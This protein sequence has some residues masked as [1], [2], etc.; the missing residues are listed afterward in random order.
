MTKLSIIAEEFLINGFSVLPAKKD[1]S[2]A[3]VSWKGLISRPMTLEY[4]EEAFQNAHFIGLIC[5]SVS[6]GIECID[7]DAHGKDIETIYKQFS[8]EHGVSAILNNNNIYI[9][10]SP[11]GGIHVIYRY[12]TTGERQ[13][14]LKLAYWEDDTSMIET[15]GTGG[16]VIVAPSE[17]Y[18][19]VRGDLFKLSEISLEER[20][21][22]MEVARR[23]NR[24]TKKE[25]QDKS[26]ESGHEYIDP[27]DWFNY[28][29]ADAAK[30][31]LKDEG[32][33]LIRIDKQDQVEHWRRPGKAKGTSATWGYKMN[34]FYPFTSSDGN[35]QEKKYYTPFQI[36]TILR[37]K[38][39]F[40]AA[41]SYVLNKYL[42]DKCDYIRVGVDY[43][44]KIVKRDRYMIE[45]IEL[46]PWKKDEIKQDHGAKYLLSIPLY[47][48]FTI[49]PDNRNYQ[50]IYDNCFNLYK[51]FRHQP[52]PGSYKW[53]EILLKHVFG[54]QYEIGLRYI[55]ALYLH[56][57]R[58]LP[59]LVLVSK[60]RQ[61]GKTTFINWLN[62]V[63]GNNMTNIN[64]EDLVSQF[65][66]SYATSN[67]IAVEETLIEKSVTVEK[68]KALA[69]GKFI[70]VNNKF[71]NQYKIPFFGKI[72][73]ASNNEDKFAKIDDE[74]IRFFVRK[75][76]IPKIA[77]HNI[78]EDMVAEIPAFLH[79][80]T[81]LPDID[82]SRDRSG[83]TPDEI[84]NESLKN[85]K[86][87]S[88]SGL[89]KDL[90]ELFKDR[91]MHMNATSLNPEISN[92]K[93][94]Y[95]TEIFAAPIDIK[96]RWFDKNSRIDIQYIKSVLKNEFMKLPER[97]MRYV[98]FNDS[99]SK[100]GTPYRFDAKEF[101]IDFPAIRV[102]LIDEFN[103]SKNVK[104]NDI[105]F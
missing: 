78:E 26:E 40:R 104:G 74:E 66:G 85:V 87:E 61:T 59:I 13:G 96:A 12:E 39:N 44:K 60:E 64:P 43:Y 82:W 22:M 23:F 90:F 67:I 14:S 8:E 36:L 83:F 10:R 99:E 52:K 84:Y 11:S 46:K 79:H 57:R 34:A 63:F 27:V 37:F 20:D 105:P 95:T 15:K 19:P 56:P 5:G 86:R 31:L 68:L 25:S 32:W 77:N 71:V 48:D 94:V 62:A 16:Y 42:N 2:P 7:F 9:E 30:M 6:G 103:K 21:Y 70:S 55:Q 1:K 17:G 47:D 41:E 69:T 89:Y 51:P 97:P 24:A 80:L 65:N 91:F 88:K 98:P 45:Q 100:T 81:T 18:L 29:K 76:E 54:E 28:H 33:E 73:L 4:S 38:R 50:P 3:L 53:T 49:V 75:L 93:D 35:F 102:K 92:P 72:V 101:G 58:S